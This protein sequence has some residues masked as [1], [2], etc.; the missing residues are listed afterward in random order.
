[1]ESKKAVMES[2]NQ[3]CSVL[4]RKIP[5]C[6]AAIFAANIAE[7]PAIK[8]N[9]AMELRIC[10]MNFILPF[11]NIIF[12]VRQIDSKHKT[13]HDFAAKQSSYLRGCGS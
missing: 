4:D 5:P 12:T 6:P 9:I 1:M 2:L 8:E 7:I 13:P 3:C 11:E 10:L